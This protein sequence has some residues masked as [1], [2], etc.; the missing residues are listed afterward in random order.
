MKLLIKLLVKLSIPVIQSVTCS[1]RHGGIA[2]KLSVTLKD[3]AIL[4][5]GI[6]GSL[7]SRV[8]STES[9]QPPDPGKR[10]TLRA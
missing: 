8:D 5:L 10:A 6:H 2:A 9:E 3:M 1:S 7:F 4:E